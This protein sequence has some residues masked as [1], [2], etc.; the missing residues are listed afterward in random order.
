MNQT[1]TS[2]N[3]QVNFLE[4]FFDFHPEYMSKLSAEEQDDMKRYFLFGSGPGEEI[5]NIFAYRRKLLAV[6][7]SMQQRAEAA[8]TKLWTIAHLKG[9]P[10]GL[11]A[12]S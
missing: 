6:D 8:L 11:E 5:D 2:Y 4:S 1:D 3:D 10:V 12:K 7:S 9:S